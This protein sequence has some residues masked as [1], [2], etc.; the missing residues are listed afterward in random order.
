MSVQQYNNACIPESQFT[1][2][3]TG[4]TL[5]VQVPSCPLQAR[6]QAPNNSNSI[7]AAFVPLTVTVQKCRWSLSDA[8][9]ED[10]QKQ[11][12]ENLPYFIL[13]IWKYPLA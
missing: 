2:R 5:P 3:L 10:T 11:K 12:E 6:P 9:G 4:N 1:L 13:D 8:L 7:G